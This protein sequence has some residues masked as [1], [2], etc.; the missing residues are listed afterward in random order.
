MGTLL[1]F[2]TVLSILWIKIQTIYSSGKFY[3]SDQNNIYF[4]D[5][6]YKYSWFDA[7]TNC[8]NLNMNLVAIETKEKSDEINSLLRKEFKNINTFW[9]G[10]VANGKD[11]HYVWISN[12]HTVSFTNWHPGQPD[13]YNSNEYCIQIGRNNQFQWNDHD[14]VVE[15]GLICEFNRKELEQEKKL[16]ETEFKAQQLQRELIEIQQ[17]LQEELAKKLELKRE[18]ENYQDE[19]QKELAKEQELQESLSKTQQ[20]LQWL[21]YN[22]SPQH[23]NDNDNDNNEKVK[24]I[25][26]VFINI[27]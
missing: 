3:T 4:I 13:F 14:C 18:H 17:N 5:D 26:N 7:L 22:K 23:N 27:N 6:E 16:N 19:L 9:I 24:P 12:G 11:R 15:F 2:L 20:L 8:V 21:L 1:Q 10:A 25:R